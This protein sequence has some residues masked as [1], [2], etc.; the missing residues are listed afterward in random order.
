[1]Y[2]N[3]IR[4]GLLQH[5]MRVRHPQDP[6]PIHG[7]PESRVPKKKSACPT[8][9]RPTMQRNDEPIDDGNHS[10]PFAGDDDDDPGSTFAENE[11]A[12]SHGG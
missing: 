7:E 4:N 11:G 3:G 10:F 5:M 2:S 1:M 6:V 8:K 9:K 12:G